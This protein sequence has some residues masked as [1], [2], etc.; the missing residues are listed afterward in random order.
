VSSP[1]P[2]HV[3]MNN[4]QVRVQSGNFV[5]GM[6][7]AVVKVGAADVP[8][9][10][11]S[12]T[13]KY[14]GF[15]QTA[16]DKVYL[17]W[18][19]DRGTGPTPFTAG[20]NISVGLYVDDS[21]LGIGAPTAIVPLTQVAALS[22]A[23]LNGHTSFGGT[24]GA[25]QDLRLVCWL[26]HNGNSPTGE[27]PY[28]AK[29]GSGA[30]GGAPGRPIVG[31]LRLVGKCQYLAGDIVRGTYTADTDGN[32]V[33]S[34]KSW[35]NLTPGRPG[36]FRAGARVR[37][38]LGKASGGDDAA[39]IRG[40]SMYAQV[41]LQDNAELAPNLAGFGIWAISRDASNPGEAMAFNHRQSTLMPEADRRTF[42]GPVMRLDA[43]DPAMFF[44]RFHIF[45]SMLSGRGQFHFAA[46]LVGD[47]VPDLTVTNETCPIRLRTPALTWT[48]T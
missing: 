41:E 1:Y 26:T 43:T 7:V 10:S 25:G 19:F 3:H 44:V 20:V 11:G 12:L 45:S 23:E 37:C 13:D 34:S 14:S 48:A 40:D 22:I 27:R 33:T 9:P 5:H 21:G 29:D 24:N 8:N 17:S 16:A 32:F 38:C 30:T 18:Y 2:D 46:P 35:S 39:F 47:E 15:E 28:V 36:Y 4:A 31:T 6:S 42:K